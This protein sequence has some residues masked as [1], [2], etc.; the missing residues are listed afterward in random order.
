MQKLRTTSRLKLL[1]SLVAEVSNTKTGRYTGRTTNKLKL[2]DS[3]VAEVS[4]TEKQE[5]VW[6]K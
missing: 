5:D 3:L 6:A 4:N 2:L 1:D